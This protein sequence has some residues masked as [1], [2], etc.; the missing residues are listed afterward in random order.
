MN[1]IRQ[2]VFT[3]H[4]SI[5]DL[6]GTRSSQ[7]VLVDSNLCTH[8][9]RN[10]MAL[11]MLRAGPSDTLATCVLVDSNL[12]THITRNTMALGMLRA[13]PSDTLATCVN[14]LFRILL[15]VIC[16]PHHLEPGGLGN[17]EGWP[18]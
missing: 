12:C 2:A 18:F 14:L 15:I 5:I 9:T 17:A 10:T 1:T 11:G 7:E 13:G 3:D 8:I 6:C 16:V 4:M